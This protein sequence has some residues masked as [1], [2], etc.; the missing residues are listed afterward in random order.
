MESNEKFL[1][2]TK[3]SYNDTAYYLLHEEFNKPC[4][5]EFEK[6]LNYIILSN[7]T[8]FSSNK[9]L[10]IVILNDLNKISEKWQNCLSSKLFFYFINF[11]QIH[12]NLNLENREQ[13][14]LKKGFINKNLLLVK[15]TNTQKFLISLKFKNMYF[16]AVKNVNMYGK[17]LVN[18]EKEN[19]VFRLINQD[20]FFNKDYGSIILSCDLVKIIDN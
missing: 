1:L 9:N 19:V 13:G 14:F 4:K 10:N 11:N 8:N 20:V 3:H 5:K 16:C 15:S 6:F 12:G 18:K 2:V 17:I 7:K